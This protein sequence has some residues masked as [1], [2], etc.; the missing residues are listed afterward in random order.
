MANKQ[1]AAGYEPPTHS[2]RVDWS[3]AS[4]SRRILSQDKPA[5]I[6]WAVLLCI[7]PSHTASFGDTVG[8]TNLVATQHRTARSI[9]YSFFQFFSTR[10]RQPFTSTIQHSH[11]STIHHSTHQPSNVCTRQPSTIQ[12]INFST[13]P[14]AICISLQLENRKH[15]GKPLSWV[16]ARRSVMC[17]DAR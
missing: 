3:V 16:A 11:T 1:K 15:E 10:A 14:H 13:Q 6:A 2:M 12:H 5:R 7:I 8:P 17:A 4:R 9:F